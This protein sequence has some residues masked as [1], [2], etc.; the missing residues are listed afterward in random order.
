MRCGCILQSCK[1]YR[2]SRMLLIFDAR[3]R[4][5]PFY[6]ADSS[7]PNTARYGGVSTLKCPKLHTGS[8]VHKG[9]RRVRN[10]GTYA[11]VKWLRIHFLLHRNDTADLL[12]GPAYY[13]GTKV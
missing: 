1:P 5:K 10:K 7:V 12:Q 9:C 13:L 4:L 11:G 8:K 2:K 6:N 3:N